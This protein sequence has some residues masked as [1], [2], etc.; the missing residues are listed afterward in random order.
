MS[1][2]SE[3]RK[4]IDYPVV[5][6]DNMDDL[7]MEIDQLDRVIVDLLS[8]RQGFMEQ[9]A[10]IKQD[11]NLVRDERRIEDVVA[12]VADHAKKV[13]AHPELVENLYR[14]MIEWCITY[15]MDVFDSLD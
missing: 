10:R 13:G 1:D 9:A 6:Y 15:E 2:Y 11:R 7:R 4:R 14:Q 5:E 3:K 8:I 12:K